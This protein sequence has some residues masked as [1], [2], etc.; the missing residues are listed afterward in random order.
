MIGTFEPISKLYVP[1]SLIDLLQ[2]EF[3][4][5]TIKILES[6]G[7][8]ILLKDYE[9][10][11]NLSAFKNELENI[12]GLIADII[13]CLSCIERDCVVNFRDKDNKFLYQATYS[14]V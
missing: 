13:P 5:F 7:E 1:D 10:P 8:Y 14:K 6:S 12:V 4:P 2:N 11:V 3:L 9:M